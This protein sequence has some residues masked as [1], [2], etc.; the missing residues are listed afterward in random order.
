M[1]RARTSR[2]SSTGKLPA[3]PGE[4]PSIND[5]ADHITTAFPEVRLK[6][7]IEMRGA[8][9]GPY[10]TLNALPALWVGLLYDQT[11]LDAAWDLVKDWTVEDHDYLRSH[12][13]RTGLATRFQGRPLSELGREV[14]EI[15]HAGLRARKRLDAHGNDETIYLAPLDRAVASGLAPAD[16]LLEKWQGEWGGDFAPL[17]R[18]YAY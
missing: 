11:A 13:P 6:R 10:A 1:P 8:D 4:L 15:A 3:R 7:Y 18:D 9:S 2:I 17:F 5:W 16:E 12:T 14:V